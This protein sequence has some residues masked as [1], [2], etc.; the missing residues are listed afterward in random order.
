VSIITAS[1]EE[2]TAEVHLALNLGPDGAGTYGPAYE[3]SVLGGPE[4]AGRSGAPPALPPN[5]SGPH[6]QNGQRRNTT[7]TGRKWTEREAG[8][9]A[10][11]GRSQEPALSAGSEQPRTGPRISPLPDE[12]RSLTH[13]TGGARKRRRDG[14][15][16]RP[17]E[18]KMATPEGFTTDSG[19][20]A[21]EKDL[22]FVAEFLVVAKEKGS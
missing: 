7:R 10:E 9:S 11:P 8:D 13:R 17:I 22:C 4:I 6:R 19:R 16:R 3:P 18:R 15:T 20:V 2:P 21:R 14:E 5:A 1:K 12:N